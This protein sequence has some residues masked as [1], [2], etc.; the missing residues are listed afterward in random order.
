[1]R[2]SRPLRW[3]AVISF[4]CWGGLLGLV[5]FHRVSLLQGGQLALLSLAAW[6]FLLWWFPILETTIAWTATRPGKAWIG[7]TLER[8]AIGSVALVHVLMAIMI[9]FIAR[10]S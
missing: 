6:F 10:S 8:V 2:R 4:L 3:T 9:V 7:V 1:M 5:L